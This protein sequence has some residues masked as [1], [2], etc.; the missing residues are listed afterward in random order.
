MAIIIGYFAHSVNSNVDSYFLII[1]QHKVS[2]ITILKI[3]LKLIKH[4][5][6]QNKNKLQQ[7]NHTKKKVI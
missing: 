1:I 6:F 7:L 4:I 2:Q 5:F 3:P